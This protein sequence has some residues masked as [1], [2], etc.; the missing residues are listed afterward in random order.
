MLQL[1]QGGIE[2][3][4][5]WKYYCDTCILSHSSGISWLLPF[6]FIESKV[7]KR[8]SNQIKSS[9]DKSDQINLYQ[10]HIPTKKKH[11]HEKEYNKHYPITVNTPAT[12]DCLQSVKL[13]CERYMYCIKWWKN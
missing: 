4:K 12:V 13:M 8:H 10:A 1:L 9:Q 6:A 11:I 7:E 3:A 5:L 2:V